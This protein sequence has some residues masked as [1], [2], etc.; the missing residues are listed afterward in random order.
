MILIKNQDHVGMRQRR[1]KRLFTEDN[2]EPSKSFILIYLRT[3]MGGLLLQLYLCIVDYHT[4]RFDWFNLGSSTEEER[5][6]LVF[7]P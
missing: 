7:K 6:T 4:K 3:M 2:Q 1:E 5:I